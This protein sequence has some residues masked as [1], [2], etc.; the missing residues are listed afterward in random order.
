MGIALHQGVDRFIEK[1]KI[2]IRKVFPLFVGVD[3]HPSVAD[4]H[5]LFS[6]WDEICTVVVKAKFEV[7]RV[8]LKEFE[9]VG[10]RSFCHLFPV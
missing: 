7:L 9:R 5:I 6:L 1:S 4:F 8:G 3:D 2:N 10:L